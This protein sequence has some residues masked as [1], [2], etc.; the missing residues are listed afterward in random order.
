MKK[1]IKNSP[2]IIWFDTS[3]TY[4]IPLVKDGVLRHVDNEER[5]GNCHIRQNEKGYV[6][7]E[8]EGYQMKMFMDQY[9]DW[10]L[11]TGYVKKEV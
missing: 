10:L 5:I 7:V 3:I 9:F 11:Y 6:I 1:K 4:S 2:D 8:K